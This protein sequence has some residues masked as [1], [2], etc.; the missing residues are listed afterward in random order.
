MRFNDRISTPEASGYAD[1]Q[2]NLRM[3]N[4][5][6]A[7]FRLKLRAVQEFAATEHAL[8][9][10]RRSFEPVAAEANRPL[11]PEETAL[12]LELDTRPA[13]PSDERGAR[14][15]NRRQP[16]SAPDTTRFLVGLRPI[17]FVPTPEGGML[18]WETGAFE[19][20]IQI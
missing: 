18:N 16:M 7:E 10:V 6:V 12:R 13:G 5:H 20:G 9:E 3:S 2:M 14:A 8:Y 17:R 11:T 1:I 19:Y 15:G 4:G